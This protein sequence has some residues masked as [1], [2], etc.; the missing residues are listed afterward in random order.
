MVLDKNHRKNPD[1][2]F[3]HDDHMRIL[4]SYLNEYKSGLEQNEQRSISNTMLK[5]IMGSCFKKMS[6]RAFSRHSY[7][8]I[9]QLTMMAGL[10]SQPGFSGE[11]IRA[12]PDPK[13]SKFLDT[14][15]DPDPEHPEHP[16]HPVQTFSEW[17]STFYPNSSKK[18]SFRDFLA[19]ASGVSVYK[20][21]TYIASSFF[22]LLVSSLYAYL[23]LMKQL[24]ESI[25]TQDPEKIRKYV[26]KF[27]NTI[28][29]LYHVT[30]SNA[31]KVYFTNASHLMYNTPLSKIDYLDSKT[32]VDAT[33]S[34][35]IHPEVKVDK[36]NRDK[37]LQVQDSED[38]SF[39]LVEDGREDIKLMYRRAFMSFVDHLASL[40]LLERRCIKIPPDNKIKLSLIA[41][42]QSAGSYY[43]PWEKM[44]ETI[45]DTCR[46]HGSV[47]GK[48]MVEK[49]M[50]HVTVI[51]EKCDKVIIA[52]RTLLAHHNGKGKPSSFNNP[53]FPA[54]IHCESS[55]AAI[56]CHL[57]SDKRHSD[58][59]QVFEAC[60]S[61]LYSS[62]F[63]S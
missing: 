39:D 17:V 34:R 24:H 4:E 40:R 16:E 9:S 3:G 32:L 13:L 36:E 30:H 22:D 15:I 25:G 62:S 11:D 33:I 23:C 37:D 29:I 56:L 52:F 6:R 51:G 57:H 43:F 27:A 47:Q 28:R 60:P 50:R 55:L 21:D 8:M 59:H 26:G 42:K 18:P 2:K 45:H 5:Y 31:M 14:V 49:I 58:L 38:E 1:F 10:A 35:R 53:F 61:S 19:P 20:F 46:S 44:E 48:D 63:T 12:N 7:L 41:V 54:S